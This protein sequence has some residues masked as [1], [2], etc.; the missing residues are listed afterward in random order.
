MN[1]TN[2]LKNVDNIYIVQDKD[3]FPRQHGD[4]SFYNLPYITH[5]KNDTLMSMARQGCKIYEL[6]NL[7]RTFTVDGL[8][9][10]RNDIHF[11]V[12][13]VDGTRE[14]YTKLQTKRMYRILIEYGVD[15]GLILT[16]LKW[17]LN[18]S[19]LVLDVT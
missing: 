19:Q 4:G 2:K 3:G 13:T 1:S 8:I 10:T 15:K 12:K 18:G 11:C 14:F 5:V 7:P 6:N 17:Y 16:Q 9:Y